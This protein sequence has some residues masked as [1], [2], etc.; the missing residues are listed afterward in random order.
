MADGLPQEQAI[1]SGMR[2]S[3]EVIVEVAITEAICKGQI[4]FHISEN[5]VILTPGV[6]EKGYLPPEY[7]RSIFKVKGG[8]YLL[9][10]PIDYVCVYDFECN[11]VQ[12]GS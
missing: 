11:C 6:G 5:Q 1:I 7:L 3:C 9:Q 10:K 4:P 2:A 12:E 8:E